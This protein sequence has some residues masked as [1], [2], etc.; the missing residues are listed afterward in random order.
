MYFLSVVPIIVQKKSKRIHQKI[1]QIA[2]SV[3]NL[4]K[5]FLSNEKIY[6]LVLH[7]LES[8]SSSTIDYNVERSL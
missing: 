8:S 6:I 7:F 2:T 5:Q 4:G 3:M 1:H